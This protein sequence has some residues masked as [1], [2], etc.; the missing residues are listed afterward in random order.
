MRPELTPSH[1]KV[2]GNAAADRLAEAGRLQ[3][4]NNKRRRTEPQ[5]EALG[6]QPMD[7]GPWSE[8]GD[9][10]SGRSESSGSSGLIWSVRGGGVHRTGAPT[11][12]TAR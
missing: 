9:T 4:P 11:R 12:E 3:H 2:P 5:W 1:M 10:D 8:E 7:S 6:L